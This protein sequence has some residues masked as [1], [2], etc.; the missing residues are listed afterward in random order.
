VPALAWALP[1]G[2]AVKKDRTRAVPGTEETIMTTTEP[3]A[4]KT[5]GPAAGVDYDAVPPPSRFQLRT[6]LLDAGSLSTLLAETPNF[7]LKIRC[8]A[9]HEGENALHSH[10]NQDHSFVVL[11][12]TA[13]FRGPR[14]ETW[15]LSRN[16]GIMLYDGTWY[17]FENSGDEPLVVLRIAAF[18]SHQGDPNKR[19]GA[20]G[21]QIDPHTKDNLRPDKIVI[22]EGAFYE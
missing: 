2:N 17:C 19:L 9:P 21:R 8:Y 18:M 11:Q 6:P 10:H 5:E 20:N 15:D 14:G 4:A 7:Q 13:R 16:E 12:G 22:R 3:H 1:P